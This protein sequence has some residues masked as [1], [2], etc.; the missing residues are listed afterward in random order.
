MNPIVRNDCLHRGSAFLDDLRIFP[1]QEDAET[2]NT[3]PM[4]RNASIPKVESEQVHVV[5]SKL[6]K[7]MLHLATGWAAPGKVASAG[8]FWPR[9]SG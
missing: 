2:V 6:A 8:R 5:A 1:V 3:P 4:L 9:M 7:A